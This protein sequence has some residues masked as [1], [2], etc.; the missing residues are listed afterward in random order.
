MSSR[1][2][3][4]TYNPTPTNV[5]LMSTFLASG[6]KEPMSQSWFDFW[7]GSAKRNRRLPR[8]PKLQLVYSA[9][10]SRKK[11]KQELLRAQENQQIISGLRNK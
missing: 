6:N 3:S 4:D 1:S 11:T 2:T 9:A 8:Y 5:Y 7:V 10:P